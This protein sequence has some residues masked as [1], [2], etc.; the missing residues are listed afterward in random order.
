LDKASELKQA[1]LDRLLEIVKTGVTV[2]ED[3][4]P[5]TL[6]APASYLSVAK[7]FLKAF[8]PS[9][10]PESSAPVG[11]LKQFEK[12]LPFSEKTN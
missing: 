10:L 9:D 11:I 4:K 1:L 8:P 6:T 2:M 12:K 3:G 7:D 5:V